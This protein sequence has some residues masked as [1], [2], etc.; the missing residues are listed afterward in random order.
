[1]E[2]GT[3]IVMNTDSTLAVQVSDD[4]RLVKLQEGEALFTVAHKDER[5]FV[6]YAANGVIHDIGT[7]FLVHK[8]PKRVRVAVLEGIVEVGLH[9]EQEAHALP[10]PKVLRE[11]D[12][13]F[14]TDDARLSEIEAFAV[15]SA[16]AWV[17]GKLIFVEKPLADVLN[18]WE[19]YRPKSIQLTDPQLGNLPISGVFR[20]DNLGSFFHA[21]EEAFA[22]RAIHHNPRLVI[23]ERNS[24]T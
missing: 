11:G 3:T 1:L 2:E 15:K 5:P 13:L 17:E 18:E 14:Y 8:L 12:Q 21:L 24:S 4:E 6:V 10:G 9:E 23:L 20:I 22:I 16:T 19:R 7:Q